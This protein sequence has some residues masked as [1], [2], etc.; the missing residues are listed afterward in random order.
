MRSGYHFFQSDVPCF[1]KKISYKSRGSPYS[2]FY[3]DHV[4]SFQ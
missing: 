2:T 3:I 1:W 4:P